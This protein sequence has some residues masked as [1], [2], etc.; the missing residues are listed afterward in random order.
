MSVTV[1]GSG[2]YT[3]VVGSLLLHPAFQ[4]TYHWG[5]MVDAMSNILK[6][7]FPPA[8]LAMGSVAMLMHYS[9]IIERN[10]CCA[11]PVLFGII[12]TGKSLSLRIALS[13][14]GGRN[15]RFFYQRYERE[16]HAALIKKS[17]PNWD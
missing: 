7:N 11:I 9:S 1:F 15:S 16:I 4:S 3:M 10:M 17:N 2:I 6:H 13:I 12:G 5:L 14:F 8:L